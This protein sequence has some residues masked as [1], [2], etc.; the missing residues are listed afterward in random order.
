MHVFSMD[1]PF[2]GSQSLARGCHRIKSFWNKYRSINKCDLSQHISPWMPC[3][4]PLRGYWED[5]EMAYGGF[6]LVSSFLP[7]QLE[8]HSNVLSCRLCSGCTS[9]GC[10]F[11]EWSTV[12]NADLQWLYQLWLYLQWT[13]QQ[14]IMLTC[15]GCT[16]CGCIFSGLINS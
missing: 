14:L 13:D 2:K 3:Q 6:W 12:H 4:L 9:C 10:I 15:S 16:S 8:W 11:L 1:I 5:T 7:P